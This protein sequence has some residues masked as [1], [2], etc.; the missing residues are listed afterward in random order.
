MTILSH[1]GSTQLLLWR[2][3][4]CIVPFW[5]PVTAAVTCLQLSR[6]ERRWLE[7]RWF[8]A[9]GQSDE[10]LWRRVSTAT[11]TWGNLNYVVISLLE[12]NPRPSLD[13]TL[14]DLKILYELNG[15]KISYLAGIRTKATPF[16]THHTADRYEVFPNYLNVRTDYK[17]LSYALAN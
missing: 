14:G 5:F 13:R 16:A 17:V 10:G 1:F 7:Q 4:S 6:T 9:Q 2:A 12:M 15:E 3:F 8:W 11:H